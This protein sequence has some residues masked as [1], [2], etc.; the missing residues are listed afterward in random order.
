MKFPA[1]NIVKINLKNKIIIIIIGFLTLFSLILFFIVIPTIHDILDM[2][3]IIEEQRIDL[4]KKYIKG[5]NL[6]QLT[7][8][9]NKINLQLSKLEQIFISENRELEFITTLE[10]VANKNS[11]NQKINLGV[12]EDMPGYDYKK[13]TLQ[14]FLQGNFVNIMNYLIGLESLEYYV[15]VKNIELTMGSSKQTSDTPQGAV[16]NMFL[17][18]ETFW[19]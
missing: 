9:L 6:R 3:Q 13:M 15:N 16:I 4:E 1:N 8:N 19:K 2:G 7:A 5:Q 12:Q 10:G 14:L 18:T 17:L 11:T